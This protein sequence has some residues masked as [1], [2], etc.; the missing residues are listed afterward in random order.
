[1]TEELRAEIERLK[2]LVIVAQPE[3]E[4]IEFA[5]AAS[6]DGYGTRL[7]TLRQWLINA[8]RALEG[9]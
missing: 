3:M 6:D 5:E 4:R 7:I 1:M 9:E 8:R 2:D